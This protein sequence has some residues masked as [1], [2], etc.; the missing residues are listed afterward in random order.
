MKHAFLFFALFCTL[1]A[2]NNHA[3]EKYELGNLYIDSMLKDTYSLQSTIDS[4][5]VFVPG[6]GS[7]L[8]PESDGCL[9]INKAFIDH[10]AE[11]HLV[12]QESLCMELNIKLDRQFAHYCRAKAACIE[13]PAGEKKDVLTA[14]FQEATKVAGLH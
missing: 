8:M 7:A 6:S 13:M 2:C 12:S 14:K 11:Q 5:N 3:E 10:L 9:Q 1:C 4:L